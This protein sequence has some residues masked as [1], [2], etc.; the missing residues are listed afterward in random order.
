ME[1]V[2]EVREEDLILG[3]IVQ[4]DSKVMDF[5]ALTGELLS[6]YKLRLPLGI[7]CANVEFA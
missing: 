4:E 5:E 1:Q 2:T 3:A 7:V 6:C